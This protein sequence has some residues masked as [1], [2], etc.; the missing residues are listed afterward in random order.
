MKISFGLLNTTCERYESWYE[1]WSKGGANPNW[2][3][4]IFNL[5]K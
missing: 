2:R 1:L 4:E 3:T 5:C